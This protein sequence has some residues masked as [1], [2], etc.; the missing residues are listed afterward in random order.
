MLNLVGFSI[1]DD[2][3]FID[4]GRPSSMGVLTIRDNHPGM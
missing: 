4:S 2:V 1:P 3:V